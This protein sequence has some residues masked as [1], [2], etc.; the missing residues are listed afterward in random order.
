MAEEKENQ[1]HVLKTLNQSLDPSFYLDVFEDGRFLEKDRLSSPA[2]L[3]H[4]FD[5]EANPI[6]IVVP[7]RIFPRLSQLLSCRIIPSDYGHLPALIHTSYDL[8]G[9]DE[10]RYS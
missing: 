4:M 6:T 3:K 10:R 5:V 8:V 7:L 2:L 1:C 9:F